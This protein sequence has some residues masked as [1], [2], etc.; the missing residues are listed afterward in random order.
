MHLLGHNSS[1]MDATQW[2]GSHVDRIICWY[3]LVKKVVKSSHMAIQKYVL[4]HMEHNP[5]RRISYLIVPLEIV[6]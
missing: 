4:Q 6:C 5:G 2:A 3:A 1:H